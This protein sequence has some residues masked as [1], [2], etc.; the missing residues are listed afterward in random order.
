MEAENIGDWLLEKLEERG[1]SQSELARRAGIGNATL[2]RIISGARQ[3][4]PDVST[5]IARVLGERP[6]MVYR[7]AG[8]LPPGPSDEQSAQIREIVE[9]LASLP[10]GPIREQA[11]PVDNWRL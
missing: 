8:L 9:M 3:A 7:L 1:W 6:E 4:G 10:D 5:A 11:S 2:S